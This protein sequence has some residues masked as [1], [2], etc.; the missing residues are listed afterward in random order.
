MAQREIQFKTYKDIAGEI[1]ALSKK[2]YAKGGSWSLGQVCR[3]LGY[4][5]KGSLDGFPR[6]L[7][8][9]IRATLGKLLLKKALAGAKSK[10]GGATIPTSVFP[11]DTDD[12]QAVADILALLDRLDNNPALMHPSALY[13]NLT[14]AQWKLLHLR[15]SAHHLS[16]LHPAK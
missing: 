14:N 4:Y 2:G 16:F 1:E 9:I 15:H 7:P 8:W 6:L 13:G 5:Y 11:A 12:K 3:H 10:P